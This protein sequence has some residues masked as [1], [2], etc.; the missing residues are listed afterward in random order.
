MYRKFHLFDL[1]CFWQSVV[2]KFD[3]PWF[4]KSV[5][6]TLILTKFCGQPL[7][8]HK[9]LMSK[10]TCKSLTYKY[11]LLTI[12]IIRYFWEKNHWSLYL[13]NHDFED[14]GSKIFHQCYHH[15]CHRDHLVLF[16]PRYHWQTLLVHNIVMFQSRKYNVTVKAKP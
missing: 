14:T 5:V 2:F 13:T 8:S 3:K 11:K 7:F 9:L 4:F 12:L 6:K 15:S 16:L 10:N 1:P